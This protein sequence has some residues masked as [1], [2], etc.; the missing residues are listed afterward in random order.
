[1]AQFDV[2]RNPGRLRDS[3]PY[4]VVLQ[5]ARYD[6]ASTRFVAPLVL[7]SAVAV[8][9]HTL[10]PRFLVEGQPV[11]LDVFNLATLPAARLGSPIASLADEESRARII[12]A[13]DE[14]TSQA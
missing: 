10:T 12:R 6:R 14:L 1:M 4:L 5:N 2:H 7:R 9:E 13:L 11:F 3:I 8:E